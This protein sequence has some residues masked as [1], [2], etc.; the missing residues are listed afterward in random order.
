MIYFAAL[1]RATRRTTAE[2][3][4]SIS[5]VPNI[6]NGYCQF[7]WLHCFRWLSRLRRELHDVSGF[8]LA[9]RDLSFSLL[10]M[11]ILRFAI[12]SRLYL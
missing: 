8:Y 1:V 9:K 3:H 6:T 5:E 11:I 4:C 7:I 12:C 2:A 10:K